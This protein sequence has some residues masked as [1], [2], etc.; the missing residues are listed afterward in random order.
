MVLDTTSEDIQPGDK[1]L[2]TYQGADIATIQVDSKWTPNKP[3]EA[4]KCYRTSSLEHPA[5]QM[6]SMERGRHYI[7]ELTCSGLPFGPPRAGTRASA[8]IGWGETGQRSGCHCVG[9]C[10]RDADI[11]KLQLSPC[12]NLKEVHTG[13]VPGGLLG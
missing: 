12:P 5:V 4:L 1:V 3:V 10:V 2:L 9:A 6:I 11:A 7:G 13:P 8:C